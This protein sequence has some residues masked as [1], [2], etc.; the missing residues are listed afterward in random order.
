MSDSAIQSVLD[1][2][3]PQIYASFKRA[4]ELRKWPDGRLLTQ[5]QLATCL[6]A[7]IA[8]EHQH[9]PPEERTGYVPPKTTA[10]EDDSHIHTHETPISWRNS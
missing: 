5:E 1:V 8:Y 4:V 3:T 6:Q 2:M 9:L 7:I 10:C